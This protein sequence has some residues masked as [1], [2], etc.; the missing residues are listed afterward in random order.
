MKK[1]IFF[2]LITVIAFASC[3]KDDICVESTTPK[4]IVN[5]KDSNNPN[6]NKTIASLTVFAEN[7]ENLYTAQT[8]DSIAIPLDLANNYTNFIF[9]SGTV[10]D[11]LKLNYAIN[12]IF[13]SR[14]CGYKSIFQNLE[15]TSVT[16]NWI[17]NTI[18]NNATIDNETTAH[19][20]IYH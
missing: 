7:K 2:L 8:L 13:V 3:E 5:F 1:Y 6:N 9:Q 11:T 4:L 14:S 16:T 20:T 18:I 12:D 17:K 19:I 10:S 15:I